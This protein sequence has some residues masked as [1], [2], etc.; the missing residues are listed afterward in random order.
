VKTAIARAALLLLAIA[1]CSK[2]TSQVAPAGSTSSAPVASP[3]PAAASGAPSG[4]ASATPPSASALPIASA[5]APPAPPADFFKTF[6]GTAAGAK[7]LVTE[8]AKPGVDAAA[9][10]KQLRPTLADYKAVFDA[11][12]AANLDAVYSPEWERGSFVVSARPGQTEVK[13]SSATVADLKANN[14]KAKDFPGGY[15]KVASHLVGN[16]TIYRFRFVEP[17]QEQGMAYD[18]LV[19]VNAHWVLIPKPWRGLDDRH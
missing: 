12:A 14:D 18:G 7:A 13:I 2:P 15:A 17:G 11:K 8:L 6:P 1:A 19:Y 10:T 5:S 3:A 9:L 16:A 4:V